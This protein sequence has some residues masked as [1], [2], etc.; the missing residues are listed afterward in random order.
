MV[1][2]IAIAAATILAASMVKQTQNMPRGTRGRAINQSFFF[3]IFLILII[4][5]VLRQ[6]TGNDYLRYVE[7]FHLASIDAYVPTEEGFN[8]LVKLIYG[9]CGYE[10]YLLVFAVFAILTIALMLT[11]MKQQSEDFLFSF[12]LFMM[13]GYYF[14]SF[15]TMRYYF[16]LSLVMVSVTYFIR[17]NYPAFVLLVL[18]ASLFH[19]SALI[20]LLLYP[21]C[22]HRY[23][24]GEVILIFALG[25]GV[26]VFQDEV[27]EL[28]LLLYPSWEDTT[29]LAAGTSISW[30]N[31]IKCSAALL[32]TFVVRRM[33]GNVTEPQEEV[34]KESDFEG[35]K[36]AQE[37]RAL[38]LYINASFLGFCLYL[39]CWFVPEISRIGYYLTFT[40]IFLFPMLLRRISDEQET[41]RK[42]FTIIIVVA[43]IL[44]FAMFLLTAYS[45]TI[46]LLPY[47]SFLFHDLNQTPS[48]SIE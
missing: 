39:F 31:L 2:Y 16:A 34:K 5:A 22:A 23:R 21:L 10:N 13:F 30:A 27:M 17:R 7:F 4:P 26:M 24:K 1:L 33:R 36:T 12:F 20:V 11:A 15:N 42:R 40:Q 3:L 29:D 38:G 28:L 9:L 19:K 48:G 43:A 46:K 45:D 37:D 25:A 18:T 47:K 35:T 44:Y 32:L 6:E 14:Q 8:F 41:R